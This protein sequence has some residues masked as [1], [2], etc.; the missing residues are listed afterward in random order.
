VTEKLWD[1]TIG[2]EPLVATAI[3][4]GHEVRDEMRSLLK[5]S[6]SD[7]LREEDPYTGRLATIFST[8]II[9]K[10]SRFEV[11]LNRPR[12]KAVYVEPEDA[13]GLD[14]W[15]QKP[16]SDFVNQ[17]LSLY[18]EFYEELHRIYSDKTEKFN[19]FV[20]LDLHS[21][22]HRRNGSDAEPEDPAENPE[23][24]IG[25]G[26]M[27]RERWAPVVDRFISDLRDFDF[28]GRH[29]DVRENVKF[30]GANHALWT[31]ERF[32]DS[33]CVLAVEFKKIFM[34]EWTGKLDADMFALMTEALRST[35]TGVLEEIKTIGT[36]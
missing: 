35:I 11:D 13:W 22:N 31:H 7:R 8:H 30:K 10:R 28:A 1:C 16:G 32:R 33:G 14:I 24:N 19:A 23:I 3:H 21:Y 9:P 12:D 2:D 15:K 29:L 6:E 25:T 18:D 5:I 26:S 4:D 36:K 27:N 34:D 17:S 20:V